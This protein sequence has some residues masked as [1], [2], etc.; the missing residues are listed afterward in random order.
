MPLNTHS[1]GSDMP[2]PIQIVAY[3]CGIGGQ[4]AGS[5]DGPAAFRNYLE[6]FAD[7][8]KRIGW[9]SW[10]EDDRA[11]SELGSQQ[12]LESVI[13]LSQQLAQASFDIVKAGGFPVLIGGDHSAAAGYW[14]G[15]SAALATE[16]D[17]GLIWVDAHMDSHTPQTSPNGYVH[18]MPLAALLGH[19]HRGLTGLMSERPKFKPGQVCLIGTRDYE[20]EEKELLQALGVRIFF[21]D[22]IHYRGLPAVFEDALRIVRQ[23][24]RGYGVTIDLDGLN[25]EDAP[26]VSTPAANGLARAELL[27][28]MQ[29]IYGDPR[30]VGME[31]SEFNPANDIDNRTLTLMHALLAGLQ[32]TRDART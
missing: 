9:H 28:A 23:A 17:V 32:G 25:P 26:G 29:G 10:I 31:I 30:L 1:G 5:R 3:A 2:P 14:S 11:F 21:M 24:S 8:R 18:G 22:E 13:T 16:G 19:G 27:A 6:Q 12:V 15:I 20:P 4:F 7:M